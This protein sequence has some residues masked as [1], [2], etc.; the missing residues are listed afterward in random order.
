MIR[1][2]GTVFKERWQNMLLAGFVFFLLI[3]GINSFIYQ[4][5][6]SKRRTDLLEQIQTK[7]NATES[8]LAELQKT[9][10]TLQEQNNELQQLSVCMLQ[11]QTGG[12][13]TDKEECQKRV[14]D[15]R[16][17]NGVIKSTPVKQSQ[18]QAQPNAAPAQPA[19]Q[20]N[21]PPPADEGL[22]PDNVFLIG[23]L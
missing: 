1:S 19:P 14:D 11:L 4:S 17:Q 5:E 3:S 23:G 6:S 21:N 22:I 9:G 20:T 12:D 16:A 7:L 15:F 18:P 2:V 10:I 8:R 13:F